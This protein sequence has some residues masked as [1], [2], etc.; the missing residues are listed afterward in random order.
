MKNYLAANYARDQRRER[1]SEQRN[2]PI[3][4]GDLPLKR[5]DYLFRV[6]NAENPST[7]S[8]NPNY[9]KARKLENLQVLLH[10]EGQETEA[11][12]LRGCEYS[13]GHWNGG[14]RV[15][16]HEDIRANWEQFAREQAN[17]QLEDFTISDVRLPP[18]P[19]F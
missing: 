14:R 5:E 9:G 4:V 16:F 17:N 1:P 3:M 6:L 10:L 2:D 19:F 13:W 11:V 18:A 12:I 15:L 7:V 8:Y